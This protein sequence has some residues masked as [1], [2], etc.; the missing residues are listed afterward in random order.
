TLSSGCT[1]RFSG[2]G[3][4]F[5]GNRRV[6]RRPVLWVSRPQLVEQLFERAHDIRG[7]R[8]EELA[9]R[10][11]GPATLH[12]RTGLT[13]A[14]LAGGV[15]PRIESALV[16]AVEASV[17]DTHQVERR[18][19]EAPDVAHLRQKPRDHR[20]LLPADRGVVGEPGGDEGLLERHGIRDPDALLAQVGAAA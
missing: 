5:D 16:E 10:A 8:D 7:P 3:K 9:A 6:F 14:E 12:D 20:A 2:F 1:T 15:V 13:G 19:A 18:R 11:G 4:P 17:R